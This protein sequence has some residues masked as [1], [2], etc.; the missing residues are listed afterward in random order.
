MKASGQP[1]LVN[2]LRL[3]RSSLLYADHVDLVAPSA[4]WMREFRPLRGIDADDPWMTITALPAET[5]RRIGV[6]DVSPRDFRRGMRRLEVRPRNDPERMEAERLWKEYIPEMRKQAEEVFDSAEA[7][8]L[9][10][11]L[12]T[13][14]VTMI[15]GGTRFEDSA[16]LQVDWFRDR[17]SRALTDPGSHLL[18]DEVTTDFLRASEDLADAVPHVAGTRWRRASVGTGLVER[19]PTFPDAPM[20]QVIEARKELAEGRARYRASVKRLADRLESSAL[21]AT[22]PSEIDELWYDEVRPSL[23]DLRRTASKAQVAVETTKRLG[24]E[25]LPNL[26]VGIVGLAELAAMLPSATVLATAAGRVAA[27]GAGE[28]FK[29][30]STVRHHDLVYLLDVDKKLG[31]ARR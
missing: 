29:A 2:E 9:D 25:Y 16:D 24:T 8:Q 21:D 15:S 1:S 18:L 22:L 19:L 11:A 31:R 6:T 3:L 27:A 23:D 13:G 28:A 7:V 26:V 5:L 20:S 4:A 30:R 14:A 12:D 10:M 17:L